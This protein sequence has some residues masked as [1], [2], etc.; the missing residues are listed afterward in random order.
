MQIPCTSDGIKLLG[1]PIGTLQ[2]GQSIC[3][4][5]I[6]QIE[7]DLKT[8]KKFPH[9]HQ[10]LKLLTF[11][12]NTRLMYFLRTIPADLFKG[13]VQKSD[14]NIDNFLA[15]TLSFPANYTEV[16][17]HLYL[18]ALDQIRLGIRD[19]GFGCYRNL[20]LH[21]AAQY[22]AIADTIRWCHTHNIVMPWLSA[23]AVHLLQNNIKPFVTNL[24]QWELPVAKECPSAE[25]QN[26]S[27]LPLQIPSAECIPH[28]PSHLFPTQGDFGRH[29]KSKLKSN[30]VSA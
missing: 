30:F 5:I 19:G 11:C 13:D 26:K 10:R 29:I 25:I 15:D 3:S 9:L 7:N 20:P 8:L 18:K 1:A 12:T 16:N 2:Y 6:T 14:D 27:G 4:T 24:E 23:P 28:W 22:S 21:D 17:S